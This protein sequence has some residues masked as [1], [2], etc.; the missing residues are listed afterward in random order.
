MKVLLYDIENTPIEA[1]VWQMFDAEVV[2]VLRESHL[3]SFAYKWAGEKT[4]HVRALP[5]YPT[6]KKDPR[7]DKELVRE[8]WR[9]F[10]EADIIIAHNGDKFDQRKSNARFIKWGLTPPP[11]YKTIDTLKIAR[12]YFKFESNRLNALGEYLGVG[13][14]AKTGGFDLWWDCINGDES[15][16]RL[17]KKYNKQDVVLLE[18]VYEAL[19]PW[20][21]NHPNIN[22]DTDTLHACPSC[23]SDRIIKRGFGYT[24]VG[25]Y[26][27]Y[28]CD[29]CGKWSK[30]GTMRLPVEIR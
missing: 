23:G 30:S 26:Q 5:D 16:W 15:A 29:L 22:L 10:Q 14:K 19:R 2:K 9:L 20:M 21:H 24:T 12:K 11:P 13:Q 27:R 28:Q 6:Y 4:T 17:M 8:L 3:L 7:S 1:M 18:S 25:R